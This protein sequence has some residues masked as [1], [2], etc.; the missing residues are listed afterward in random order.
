MMIHKSFTSSLERIFPSISGN[1]LAETAA[2]KPLL[3]LSKGNDISLK[4]G[5]HFFKQKLNI[6]YS[7]FTFSKVSVVIR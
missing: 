2:L 5:Q 7:V 3:N 6:L 1:S 4:D